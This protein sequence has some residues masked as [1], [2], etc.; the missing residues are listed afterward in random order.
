MIEVQLEDFENFRAELLVQANSLLFNSGCGNFKKGEI[1][2]LAKDLVQET[3]L[4]FHKHHKDPFVTPAHLLNFIRICLYRKYLNMVNL[5]R[6]SYNTFKDNNITSEVL[7]SF[8]GD[9]IYEEFDTIPTFIKKLDETEKVIV[10]KLLEGYTQ[11]EIA[12]LLKCNS[13]VIV[14]RLVKIRKI[15]LNEKIVVTKKSNDKKV[16]QIDHNGVVVKVWD[17]GVIAADKLDLAAS[18]IS[19]CCHGKRLTHGGYKWSFVE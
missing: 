12:E 6:A 1:K 19:N 11:L 7:E 2:E 15:Y 10:F 4:D 14:R 3:Y 18:A 5:K 9:S 8:K 16:K 17:S 13:Q